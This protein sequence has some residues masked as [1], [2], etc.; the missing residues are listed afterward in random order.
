MG[1]IFIVIGKSATGKDSVYSALIGNMGA[2]IKP[3][4]I[5]T[6]RPQRSGELNGREYYF[7]DREHLMELEKQG[8]V[9]ESRVY[10]TVFGDWFYFT[11][12]E[13][14]IGEDE[15]YLGIGTLESFVKLKEYYGEDR[16]I[17]IY[18]ECDD[19]ERLL[20]SVNRE[21]KQESPSYKEVCRRYIADEEDFSPEK[22]EKAG[23]KKRFNNDGSLDVCAGE[24][25]EYIKARI[26]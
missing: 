4:V 22:I 1:K 14:Q 19:R 23:I 17:P 5:F 18:I 16:V 20:R 11:A 7:T 6:T 8:R 12:D 24:I 25:A 3:F 26:S 2:E 21:A 9:I 13:G 15:N 10:H